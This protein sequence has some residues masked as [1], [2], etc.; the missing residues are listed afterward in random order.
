MSKAKAIVFSTD[1]LPK[2]LL[3][4]ASLLLQQQQ[5][6]KEVYAFEVPQV[7][8]NERKERLNYKIDTWIATNIV[9]T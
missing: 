6:N 3:E 4:A 7:H 1:R 2:I 9:D 5:L 8:L